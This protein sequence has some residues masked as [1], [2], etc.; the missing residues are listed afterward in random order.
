MEIFKDFTFE[1]AHRLPNLPSTHKCSRL[2]GHTFQVRLYVKGQVTGEQ[3]WLMD[4]ADIESVFAPVLDQIDHRYLN[5]VEG[6][7]NPTSEVIAIWIWDRLVSKL[8]GLSR[9]QVMEN[10]TSGCEFTGHAS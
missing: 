6:L 7:S 5:E 3:G 9:V 1:S 8:P 10:C 2:H 4:F